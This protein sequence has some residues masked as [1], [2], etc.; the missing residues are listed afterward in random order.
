MLEL[1]ERQERLTVNQW[2]LV[3]AAILGGALG[4]LALYSA[5]FALGLASASRHLTHG[6][7]ALIHQSTGAGTVIG[8]IFWGWMADR[9]GRRKAFIATVLNVSLASGIMTLTPDEGGAIFL[10]VFFLFAGLGSAGLFV[11]LLPLVQEFV[12]ASKRG[13]I[14]GLVIAVISL[15][16]LAFLAEARLAVRID[17][18]TLFVLGLLPALVTLLIRAWVPES[19]RWLIRN[20]RLEDARRS[21]AWALRMDPN[22]IDLPA[23]LPKM[24][25]TPWPELF[26]YRRSVVIAC[27]ISLAQIEGAG[28]VAL[29]TGVFVSFLKISWATAG[30]L[31]L[32]VAMAGLAGQFVM[33]YLSDAIGRR[34]SGMLCGFG[35]AVSLGL[36]GC[37]DE[38][39]FVTVSVFWL[40]VMVTSF[41]AIG[42]TAIGRP[43]TA[44]VWPAGLR[45]SGMGLAYAFGLLG[46]L[47]APLAIELIIGVPSFLTPQAIPHSVWPAT[48]F[49]A[50]FYALSGLVFWLL[51]IETRGRTIE[52]IDATLAIA[53]S[54]P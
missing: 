39:F 51:A 33:S 36:A 2:K 6:E 25:R 38:A 20:R 21:L 53:A 35:A 27:V 44:E 18:H 48:L 47:L 15:G 13:R 28:V 4:L 16:M 12:P 30:Y 32:G 34:N 43:Y 24:P 41:F 37:F 11:T 26:K 8:A 23:A 19:P 40:L 31:T 14:G 49:L 22:E 45:A 50:A 17:W 54:R 1:L 42:S 3:S 29:G 52:E 46:G 5:S 7:S 10:T 9:I